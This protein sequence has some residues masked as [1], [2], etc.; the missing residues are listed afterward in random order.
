VIS[1][2][3]ELKLSSWKDTTNY[4]RGLASSTCFVVCDKRI[5]NDADYGGIAPGL[6]LGRGT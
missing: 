2:S 1:Y 6:S 4:C 5:L 3:H